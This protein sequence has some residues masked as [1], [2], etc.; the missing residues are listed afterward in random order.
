M[1]AGCGREDNDVPNDRDPVEGEGVQGEE[2]GRRPGDSNALL[3]GLSRRE[4]RRR[5]PLP[6][7]R[8]GASMT[9]DRLQ[10]CL[11]RYSPGLRDALRV[12]LTERTFPPHP[13]FQGRDVPALDEHD[14]L[15]G[16]H[17]E[18][19]FPGWVPIICGLSRAAARKCGARRPFDLE[20]ESL[21]D[22]DLDDADPEL[23]GAVVERWISGAWRAVRGVAPDLRG[24]VSIHDTN[25][26][27]DMDTGATVRLDATGLGWL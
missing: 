19:S 23:A 25:W 11:E 1:D 8:H 14:T 2:A 6:K 15:R 16:I 18:Y 7:L 10:A 21:V 3:S 13:R 26:R 17:V 27:I 5:V 22:S 12:A 20:I 4:S 24:F 9:S